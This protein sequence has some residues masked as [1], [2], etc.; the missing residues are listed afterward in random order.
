M[1]RSLLTAALVLFSPV[2]SLVCRLPAD[3]QSGSGGPSLDETVKYVNS[4]FMD[5]DR[6]RSSTV[7][8]SGDHETLIFT[9][10]FPKVDKPRKDTDWYQASSKAQVSAL[11]PASVSSLAGNVSVTCKGNASCVA[12]KDDLHGKTDGNNLD[13]FSYPPDEDE[14]ERLV[15][16]YTHLIEMLQAEHRAKNNQGDPFA[17]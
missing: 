16:A 11:D 10:Y 4:K 13:F 9:S 15:R 3:P 12:S 5:S 2:I 7:S 6:S 17:H 1:R 14:G 8:V